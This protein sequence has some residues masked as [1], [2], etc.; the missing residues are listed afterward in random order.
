M[1]SVTFAGTTLWDTTATG[2]GRV[3]DGQQPRSVNWVMEKLPGNGGLIAK[4]NGDNPSPF[5]LT[6]M[7][8]LTT[9]QAIAL[10]T[11]IEDS[12]A[13]FGSV[14]WP[15]NITKTNC[16]LI[17]A[18]MERTGQQNTTPSAGHR[19]EYIVSYQF[20]QLS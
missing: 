7:Y 6:C 19:Y 4:D 11:T 9:A 1:A 13:L 20:Q 8:W 17:N 16:I 3:R 5:A 2:V 12:R 15:P 18:A 14:N 10:V